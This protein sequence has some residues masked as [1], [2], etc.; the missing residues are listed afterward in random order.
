MSFYRETVVKAVR[1]R[2]RCDGCGKHIEIGEPAN[3]WAGMTDGD[4]GSVIMHPECREAEIK[5]NDIL[6]THS[7]DDWAG[8]LDIESEDWPW[9]LEE[10]PVVAARM[11][12]TAERITAVAA[13]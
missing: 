12:I 2:H 7:G 5:L 13:E 3:R 11:G 4:F 6:G 8:L 1:K 10:H 9:L